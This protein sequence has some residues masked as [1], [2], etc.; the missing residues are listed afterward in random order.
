MWHIQKE[1]ET[2]GNLLHFSSLKSF[3]G[4]TDIPRKRILA[5]LDCCPILPGKR[6]QQDKIQIIQVELG[7]RPKLQF[8]V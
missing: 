7:K 8:N 6:K 3:V 4:E 2:H 1:R 5:N